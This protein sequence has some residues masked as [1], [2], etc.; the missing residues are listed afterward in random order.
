MACKYNLSILFVDPKEHKRAILASKRAGIRG[1]TIVYG[2]GT[3]SNKILA[4]LGMDSLRKELLLF[5]GH[6]DLTEALHHEINQDIHL[7]KRDHGVLITLPLARAMGLTELNAECW[8]GEASMDYELITVIADNG[9]ADD[10]IDAAHAA[11]A[12]GATVL[13]GRGSGAE[14]VEK[15]FNLEIEPEKEIVMIIA[16]G[17]QAV[18][19]IDA[20][21]SVVDF[22]SPNSG[23]LFS[24]NAS[25]VT[26]LFQPAKGK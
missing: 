21:R 22:D 9:R 7:D 2:R 3:V 13:H 5:V 24:L 17:E 6:N 19:I 11:G 4:A 18:D 1:A 16:N 14:N 25:H 26:G 20:I 15:F 23:I 12:T 10:I 8:K